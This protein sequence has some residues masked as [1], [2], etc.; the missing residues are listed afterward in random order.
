[1]KLRFRGS[2][3]N[4][5]LSLQG[6]SSMLSLQKTPQPILFMWNKASDGIVPPALSK[7][8]PPSLVISGTSL[9]H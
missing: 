5:L 9:Q 6:R 8:S 7:G 2:V 4:F 1:M 3:Y